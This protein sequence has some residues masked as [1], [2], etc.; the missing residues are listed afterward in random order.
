MRGFRAE[1][2]ASAYQHT[3]MTRT[4][5]NVSRMEVGSVEANSARVFSVSDFCTSFNFDIIDNSSHFVRKLSMDNLTL[6]SSLR[7]KY[8]RRLCML[9]GVTV[10]FG[11][12][13]HPN[14]IK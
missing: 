8:P 9:S 3:T 4:S 10:A 7:S 6:K 5:V 1:M 14:N 2:E 12:R 11:S 13:P